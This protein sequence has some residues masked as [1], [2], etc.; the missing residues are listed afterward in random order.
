MPPERHKV[1]FAFVG[2]RPELVRICGHLDSQASS[3]GAALSG[4]NRY[5]GAALPPG[6]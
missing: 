3:A 2:R 4:G 6:N 5:I 1:S